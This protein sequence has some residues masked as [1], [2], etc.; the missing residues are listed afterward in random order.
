MLIFVDDDSGSEG[1]ILT[2]IIF[3]FSLIIDIQ[4]Q[5]SDT[6]TA[7]ACVKQVPLEGDTFFFFF[8][9]LKNEI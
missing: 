9:Y 1:L 3:Y 5:H 8:I 7:Q 2:F 4:F 6:H